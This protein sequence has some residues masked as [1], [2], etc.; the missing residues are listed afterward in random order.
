VALWAVAVA[1]GVGGSAA[2]TLVNLKTPA[3]VPFGIAFLMVTVGAAT[4]GAVVTTR[5][6]GNAV[7]PI[8]LA[9][10]LGLG[11]LLS[12]G[13]YAE[14]SWSTSIGPLPGAAVAAWLGVWVSIPVLFGLT[15][16]LL[17]LFPDGHLLSPRWSSAA[18]F[19]AAGVSLATVASAF[20]PRRLSPG[21]DNPVGATGWATDVVVWL[22]DATNVLALPVMVLAAVALTKRLRRSHGRERQQLKSFTY[23]AAIA[24]TTLGLSVLNDGLVADIAFFC[25]LLGLA[26]LPVVAGVAILRHGLYDIDLVIKRTLVYGALTATLVGTY[27]A[28]VLLLQLALSPVAGESDLAV[29][30]STLA[31]AALFRPLRSRLQCAVDRRFYR[32]RYDA[33]RTL[34]VF[35]AQLRDEL[36]LEALTADVRRV[37]HETVQPA[38]V[39]L[40]LRES[41]E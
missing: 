26:G 3:D 22:E 19:T 10:G 29:A 13:A 28:L 25:G 5:V 17:L 12:A 37:V 41:R 30:G 21:Y 2:V 9:M 18:W 33:A 34:E 20:T 23:V 8:L 35:A 7:G 6:P 24:G 32:Q 40:W 1:Q 27:L 38:H 4:A 14:A 16:F 31:V 39:S 36:D 11:V 15:A